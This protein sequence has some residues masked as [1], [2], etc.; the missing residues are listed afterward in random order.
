MNLV[1]GGH[2]PV[3]QNL[4][5]YI[6]TLTGFG[7]VFNPR[8]VNTTCSLKTVSLKQPPLVSA[9]QGQGASEDPLIAQGL[10]SGQPLVT[11]SG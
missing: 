2:T 3:H 8:G 6:E 1:L 5:V 4:K 10:L 11:S 9:S 7:H